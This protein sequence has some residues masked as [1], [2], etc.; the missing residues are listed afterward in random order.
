MK[1]GPSVLRLAA[2]FVVCLLLQAQTKPAGDVIVM[3]SGTFTAAHLVL[4][5]D[6]ERSTSSR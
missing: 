6:F 4:A 3:T 1:P 2:L 5:S